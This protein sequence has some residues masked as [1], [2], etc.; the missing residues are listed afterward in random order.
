ML[1]SRIALIAIPLVVLSAGCRRSP[2]TYIARGDADVAKANYA[3]AAIEY[4]NAVQGAPMRADARFKLGNV[5]LKLGS[6]Q[7]AKGEFVRAADLQPDNIEY[8]LTAGQWLLRSHEFQDARTRAQIVLKK[9]PRNV[10]GQ[11][12]LATA[13][14]G[15]KDIDGAIAEFEEAVGLD[16]DRPATYA[17]IGFLQFIRGN[18]AEAETAYRNAVALNPAAVNPRMALAQFL[19]VD[20]RRTE[21]EALLKEILRD[22][23]VEVRANRLLAMWLL[24]SGRAAE[25]EAPLKVAASA[26]KSGDA[27]LSLADYYVATGRPDDAMKTLEPLIAANTPFAPNAQL[28][29]AYIDFARGHRKEADQRVDGLL[30]A[31]P[32][33]SRALAW[34]ARFLLVEGQPD[35]ALATARA[36]IDA[37][38]QFASAHYVAGTIYLAKK[39]A[40]NA[41]SEFNETLRLNP[42][43]AGAQLRLSEINL[44]KG[45]ADAA[46]QFATGA[47]RS[48]PGNPAARLQLARS[49]LARGELDGAGKELNALAAAFPKDGGVQ[50]QL[51]QLALARKDDRKARQAFDQA[52]SFSPYELDALTGLTLMDI[53]A[54]RSAEAAARLDKKLA[55]RPKDPALLVLAARAAGANRKLDQAESF[56]RRAIEADASW[57]EAYRLLASLYVRQGRLDDARSAYEK[58]ADQDAKAVWAETLV[59]MIYD[60]QKQPAKA[61]AWY[62]RAL[63]TDPRAAVAANNLACLTADEGGS[64]DIALQL[65]QTAKAELPTT[66]EINDTLGW[67][68]FRKGLAGLAVGPLLQATDKAP[69][70]AMF[71][72]HAGMA[73]ARAGQKVQA[74]AALEKALALDPRFDGADEAR[75][76]LAALK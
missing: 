59:G 29:L 24:T 48:E 72:Y 15:L 9:S 40:D 55:D 47:A 7:S 58:I 19:W 13:M 54:G 57:L 52:L 53:A 65:A 43:A 20:G 25:A 3:D 36:A 6:W 49:L 8:Q 37:D 38:P 69:G 5:L 34:K 35:K 30:K 28:R 33:D 75:K 4:K 26:S 63:R 42:R 2:D 1:R 31:D 21:A 22:H 74:K 68:Y 39:D 32:R 41:V 64:L 66:P 60:S 17:S 44:A 51:G 56:L 11:V 76:A 23:P 50:A 67:L 14:A 45:Q 73:L 61:R 71:Q 46:V 27:T 18:R 10:E 16:P 70:N 12:L 62:E